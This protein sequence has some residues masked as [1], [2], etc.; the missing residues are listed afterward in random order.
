M[1]I[2]IAITGAS[3]F[4]GT[5]LRAFL[6]DEKIHF[7]SITRRKTRRLKFEKNIV[8]DLG[9]KDL[10]GRLRGCAALVHLIGIGAQTKDADYQSVN[11]DL[12]KK[13]VSLCKKSGIKKIVYVSGLGVSNN[14][15]FGY[16]LSKL[17]AEEEIKKSGLDYIILRASYVIGRD[18]PLTK[19]LRKQAR[20]GSILVPGDGAY[21]LQP[22]LVR[23][24]AKVI[25]AC[26]TNKKLSKKTVDLVGPQTVSFARFARRF[27][28]NENVKIRKV[29]LQR[30]Y[31]TALNRPDDAAFGLDDLNIMVGDFTGNHKRLERL[32]GFR[33]NSIG[34]LPL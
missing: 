15:T 9:Q 8:S 18:D 10:P 33:L 13:A 7:T 19:N 16:F 26:V 27:A 31:F 14:T 21:R 12:T 28:R 24:V 22:V 5:N 3:G 11:V 6:N 34:L 2:R 20:S 4:V 17:K 30:A 1:E 32:C 29:S 23:D 25:L